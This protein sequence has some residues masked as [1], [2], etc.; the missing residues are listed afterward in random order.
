MALNQILASHRIESKHAFFKD[1]PH[2]VT[3]SKRLDLVLMK[4]VQHQ[5]AIALGDKDTSSD[6]VQMKQV[7]LSFYILY[8]LSYKKSL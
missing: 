1:S 3:L 6:T 2:H 5:L 8:T 7:S 4:Q